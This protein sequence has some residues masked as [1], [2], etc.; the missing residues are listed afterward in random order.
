MHVKLSAYQE[1]QVLLPELA[2]VPVVVELDVPLACRWMQGRQRA[3]L[4]DVL[5]ECR[6]VAEKPPLAVV[7]QR[8]TK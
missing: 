7:P 6:V 2:S 5:G 3:L 1:Q 8:W 4:A